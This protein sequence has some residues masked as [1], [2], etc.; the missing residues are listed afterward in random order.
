MVT[1][2]ETSGSRATHVVCQDLLGN[3]T[4]RYRGKFIVVAA[5]SLESAKIALN[6]GLSDP[7]RKMGIGL[8]DHPAFFSARYNIPNGNPFAG[9]ENHAKVFLHKMGAT[10][11]DH[12]FNVEVL[13]NPGYW[14]VR[15]SDDDLLTSPNES[16]VEMKFLFAS[17][18]DESNYVRSRGVGQK[19]LV[20]VNRNDAG[21]PHFDAARQTRNA[22]LASLNVPF[23]ASEGMGYGNEGT[24][25]HVGGTMRTSG[26]HTG[27]VDTDLKFESYDNLYCADPSVWPMIP[28]ANP[29]LTLVALTQRLGMHLKEIL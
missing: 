17:N 14:S 12:P 18:L 26:N 22:I 4:R 11:G 20:K 21:R 1:H 10:I 25:H 7:H 9:R 8:T 29:V 27:V 6:S 5:G 24:V 2:I 23:T 16:V 28:A 3:T 15:N 13:I 19:L